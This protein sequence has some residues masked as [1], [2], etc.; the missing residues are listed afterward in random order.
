V[1]RNIVFV[2][3]MRRTNALVASLMGARKVSRKLS[4]AREI[5]TRESF[6][7]ALSN[8]TSFLAILAVIC[9]VRVIGSALNLVYLE[10]REPGPAIARGMLLRGYILKCRSRGPV[11]ICGVIITLIHL[12]TNERRLFVG[13]P[14]SLDSICIY[15]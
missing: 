5:R 3:W 12:R 8:K 13:G 10:T 1:G 15:L 6:L 14:L 9:F 4:Y 11:L 2:C 7:T